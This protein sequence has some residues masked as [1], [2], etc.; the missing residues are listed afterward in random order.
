M[1]GSKTPLFWAKVDKTAGPDACWPWTGA[2]TH[3]GYGV[4][5]IGARVARKAHRIAWELTNGPPPEDKPHVLHDCPSG[6]NPACC[7]PAHLWTG[8]NE[9]N[10][11]DKLSKQRQARGETHGSA[12]LND[13]LVRLVR[14][15]ASSGVAQ[16]LIAAQLGIAQSTVSRIVARKIW[17]HVPDL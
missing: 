4:F 3:Q 12:K 1:H 15:L 16:P 17:A 7:N 8:T 11:L 5:N 6:D 10:H 13:D 2:R 14:Q 9:D